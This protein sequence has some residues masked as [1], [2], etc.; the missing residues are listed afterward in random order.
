MKNKARF[1]EIIAIGDEILKGDILNS[2]SKMI[3]K[4]LYDIGIRTKYISV[5]GDNEDDISASV[6]LA[7]TRSDFIIITGGLGPT[8]DD[9]TKSVLAKIFKSKLIF[10]QSVYDDVK[11][12]FKRRKVFMSEI[13]RNQA[14]FPDNAEI[15]KNSMGTAPGI[16]YTAGS[17]EIFSIP[18]V[19]FEAEKMLDDYIILFIA[20]KS[21]YFIKSLDILTE[22]ISESLLFEKIGKPLE[23][24]KT[25]FLPKASG[26]VLRIEAEGDNLEKVK[27]DLIKGR[28]IY[29]NLIPSENIFSV[30]NNSLV[31]M[32]FKALQKENMTISF[33][34]SCSGGMAAEKL[35][36]LSGAS[37]VF[38]KSFVTYSNKAK[39]EIL[40][41]KNEILDKYGAVSK[42]TVT[43][44]LKGLLEITTA[45]IVGAISGIAGPLG[46][47]KQ[48]PVGTVYIGVGLR[49]K[50]IS[51]KRYNFN[52]N[53]DYIRQKS[54]AMLYLMALK[55]EKM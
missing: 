10:K 19:P 48:K 35:V 15:I 7:L 5:I 20:Q 9:I 45:D 17:I 37:R 22:N 51:V 47:T 55:I 34:E 11:D 44:M 30:G 52:G 6:N 16:H 25:S 23:F 12:F 21:D 13:N 27:N 18:G 54:V 50:N 41:V 4:K 42:E 53:R 3:A 43:E 1:A 8:N 24:V 31:E 46:G 49:D 39:N 38:N 29:L 28:D 14:I 33:A 2:N 32:L 36:A 26:V 40:G